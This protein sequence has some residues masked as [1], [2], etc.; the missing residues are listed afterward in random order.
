MLSLTRPKPITPNCI[1]LQLP[2]TPEPAAD[3][4]K[5]RQARSYVGAEVHPPD[6]PT[7]LGEHV[8]VAPSR[9]RLDDTEPVFVA[10]PCRG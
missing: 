6:T 10:R 7:A 4:A 9:R 1:F 5:G 8:E 2:L 3:I